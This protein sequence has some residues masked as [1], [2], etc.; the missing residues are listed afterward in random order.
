[1]EAALRDL[2]ARIPSAIGAVVCDDE[3]ETVV[4]SLGPAAPPAEAER[5]A[6]EHV[7]RSIALHMP[8]GE[9][10]VRLVG[11]ELCAILRAF[12]VASRDKTAGAVD[13]VQLSYREIDLLLHPL[14]EDYYLVTVLRRPV[15]LG[16]ARHLVERAA[17]AVA[18]DIRE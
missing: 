18:D 5:E 13:A 9:F 16:A 12:E 10:L 8:V 3:G 6:R 15:V 14:P 11:A 17:R 7:P 4:C 1:M 2:C